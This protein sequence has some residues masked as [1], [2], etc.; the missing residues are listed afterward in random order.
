[1]AS[2]WPTKRGKKSVWPNPFITAAAT[3][4]FWTPP[5]IKTVTH[6]DKEVVCLYI[7]AWI[8]ENKISKT[9]V[10]SGAVV[11]LISQKVVQDLKLTVYCMDE[12]W[13]LQLADDGHATVQEYVWVT[14]NIS[15]VRALVKAFILGEG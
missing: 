15:G 3:S 5:V 1:M 7:D 2:S 11:E 12:K 9:F 4:K 6:E 13:I 10:D 14:V 8:E